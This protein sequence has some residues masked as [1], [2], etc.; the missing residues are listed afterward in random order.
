MED[1]RERT[2]AE[3]LARYSQAGM[4]EKAH[5]ENDLFDAEAAIKERPDDETAVLRLEV[6]RKKIELFE[7]EHDNAGAFKFKKFGRR[8]QEMFEPGPDGKAGIEAGPDGELQISESLAE[9]RY[10]L[11]NMG[12]LDRFNKE[13][14]GHAAGD[15][16]L[17]ETAAAI[18]KAVTEALAGEKGHLKSDYQIYRFDG[19]TFMVD[20]ASLP[21]EEFGD[22]LKKMQDAK[23]E[24]AGVKDPA[25]LTVRGL[26]LVNVVSLVNH[27]QAEL[28]KEG[29]LEPGE[30][31]AREIVEVMRRSGDWDLEVNKL[32]TR[33]ERVR[34]KIEG[35][36][37]AGTRAYE[38]ALQLGKTG[39]VAKEAAEAAIA[40]AEKEAADFFENY[41]K[42]SFQDTELSTFE[43]FKTAV[44]DG[45][46]SASAEEISIKTTEKRFADGRKVD[47]AIVELIDARVRERNLKRAMAPTERMPAMMQAGETTDGERELTRKEGDMKA[48]EALASEATGPEAEI[49]KLKAQS[50]RLEYQIESSRRDKGT[51][52]LERGVHYEHL[53]K[54]LEDGKDVATL[55]VDMGF[56]K[57]FDQMGGSDVGDRALKTAASMMEE[58]LKLAGVK[59]NVYRYGGDEFTIQ[60][61][62]GDAAAKEVERALEMIRESSE[63]IAAGTKS[64][65]EYAPTRLAF[66]YGRA[67]RKML[68]DLHGLAVR[69]G[70]YSPDEL[71]DPSR[72]S[73]AK[74]E[75]MTKAA[76]VG[77]EYNKAYSRFMLLLKEMRKPDYEADPARTKQVEAMIT[78]SSKALF[79]PE[80]VEELRA[81]HK[82]ASL[83]LDGDA[84]DE[85]VIDFVLRKVAEAR[86]QESGKKEVLDALLAAQVKVEFLTDRLVAMKSIVD[87][88]QHR[89]DKLETSLKK[90]E[91]E[92]RM[93]IDAHGVIDRAA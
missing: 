13:G 73:N 49:L 32:F 77:I 38:A 7:A 60:V 70:K 14:G 83:E 86:A 69:D 2:R 1:N 87:I 58:A 72:V 55:F 5:L 50:A 42:K 41:A 75:L 15:A 89:I 62:G 71:A 53:E 85:K 52:L 26:D 81:L 61:E 17:G 84:L 46:Y 44:R 37:L 63:P 24:V 80:G 33:A 88:Q 45:S 66:N 51:G 36:A 65:D 8:I 79:G 40:E 31:A 11:V 25:P 30:D 21:R 29:K 93:A 19:N 18:E 27:V 82:D 4:M 59:G 78:F 9:R 34:G 16:A 48:A 47:D 39:D 6:A 43:A 22:L 3:E 64:R 56:L 35:I 92:R 68:E 23:P 10:M 67:D 12:E 76:D 74:A 20:I 90:A 91:E 57:Y 28:P 54:A